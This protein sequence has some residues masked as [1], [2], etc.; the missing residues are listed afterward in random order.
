MN[1]YYT[2]EDM[3]AYPGTLIVPIYEEDPVPAFIMRRSP[4]ISAQRSDEPAVR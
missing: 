2:N 1:D 3:L 4:V